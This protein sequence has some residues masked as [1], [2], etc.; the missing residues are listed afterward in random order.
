MGSWYF[1]MP[2][3]S[4]SSS[5]ATIILDPN[6]FAGLMTLIAGIAIVGLGIAP[7]MYNGSSLHGKYTQVIAIAATMSLVVSQIPPILEEYLPLDEVLHPPH[8]V[9]LGDVWDYY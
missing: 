9:N 4:L 2:K 5:D 6:N 1:S 7:M 3:I 8:A